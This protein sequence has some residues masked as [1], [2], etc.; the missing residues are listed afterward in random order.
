MSSP[1]PIRSLD[2]PFD[3]PPD[4]TRRRLFALTGALGLGVL[5][6]SSQLWRL[7]VFGGASYRELADNNRFRLTRLD[8]PRGVLYD[9][10]EQPL[11]RNRPSYVVAIVPADLPREPQRAAVLRRLARLIGVPVTR[12]EA[13]LKARAGDP[14]TP[15]PLGA[16][17]DEKL[18]FVVE[19]RHAE[20][21]GVQVLV[22]PVREYV[23]GRLLSHVIGYVGKLDADELKRLGPEGDGTYS[24]DDD[25]GKMGIELVR[26]S[27]LRGKPGEKRSEVD[28]TGRELRVLATQDAVPGHNLTLTVDM[29]LQREITRLLAEQLPAAEL[30][31]AVAIDPRTGQVLALVHLPAFHNN[32][33]S[34]E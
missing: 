24:V 15:V 26:E 22:R 2:E 29:P 16:P 19:E 8:P 17:V 7:Q 13:A 20:L 31:S 11:A 23:D 28:S 27:D 4:P 3:Q 18:A 14:F 12:I 33:F 6:L 9:R 32:M 1:D 5:G 25:I 10:N 30:A 34:R 21:A